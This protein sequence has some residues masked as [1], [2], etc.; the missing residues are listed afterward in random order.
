MYELS[1]A[2]WAWSLHPGAFAIPGLTTVSIRLHICN[3]QQSSPQRAIVGGV[4]AEDKAGHLPRALCPARRFRVIATVIPPARSQM[5]MC[6][7]LR[8]APRGTD[9]QPPSPTTLCPVSCPC[10]LSLPMV[11]RLWWIM[12]VNRLE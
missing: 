6:P 10:A 1:V 4:R 3:G 8:A 11:I 5:R 2:G 7:R 9:S 12:T